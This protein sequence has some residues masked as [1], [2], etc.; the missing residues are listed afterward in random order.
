MSHFSVVVITKPDENLKDV[1]QPYR[2]FECTG[3]DDQYVH[4]VDVTD[5]VRKSYEGSKSTRYKDP[6][7]VIHY[8]Y[9]DRFYREP[10]EE[11]KPKVGMGTGCGGGIFWTSKDW[12]DGHGYRTKVH[13]IP[14]GWEEIQ[15]PDRE[16]K[17]LAEYASGYYGT[18]I[19]PE[20][21]I[22]AED[23]KY[24]Y[25][26]VDNDGE[27]IKVIDRTNPNK[28][29]DWWKI[30]GRFS[31]MLLTKPCTIGANSCPCIMGSHIDKKG[32]DQCRAGDLD[33]EA[34]LNRNRFRVKKRY[35]EQFDKIKV[36]SPEFTWESWN[37][38]CRDSGAALSSLSKRY[39]KHSKNGEAFYQFIDRLKEEGDPDAVLLRNAGQNGVD[40]WE[41]I[42]PGD[43][44][45]IAVS[46]AVPLPSFAVI[47]DGKWYER[48]TMGWWGN[49]I[50][51]MEES[52]WNK[53]LDELLS[54][55][56]EDMVVTVVD[57]HI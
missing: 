56:S 12:G 10:T 24:R 15:I 11:E 36:K 9:L 33:L 46:K 4:D 52:D 44:I 57:C 20:G 8:P 39:D 34:M 51:K 17:T 22:T 19:I 27:V 26:L 14:E 28:K 21:Q 16:L 42:D 43:D 7:G 5:E 37:K 47:K 25:V 29:W 40:S 3:D 23:C 50:N 38:L 54:G 6:H 35:K 13:F 31:G 2:E 55:L 30:G 45:D 18:P 41:G 49:A 32:I 48:G 1:M 53:K